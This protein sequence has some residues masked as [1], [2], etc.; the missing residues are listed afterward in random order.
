MQ[1]TQGY[2]KLE[3][4]IWW[5]EM[6]APQRAITKTHFTFGPKV[7]QNMGVI[8]NEPV[9]TRKPD[10]PGPR[11]AQ[12]VFCGVFRDLGGGW[13]RAVAGARGA[14]VGLVVCADDGQ[15]RP[16]FVDQVGILT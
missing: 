16:S 12:N 3:F 4:K 2:P 10:S 6:R 13:A 11:A 8:I 14:R 1:S 7:V 5:V 15:K 9:F